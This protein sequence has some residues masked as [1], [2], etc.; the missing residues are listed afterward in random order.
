MASMEEAAGN[1]LFRVLKDHNWPY[2]VTLSRVSKFLSF[3]AH[4]SKT[5]RVLENIGY[6]WA[7]R[8][9]GLLPPSGLDLFLD[10]GR[11]SCQEFM[12][13]SSHPK[14]IHHSMYNT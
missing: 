14:P 11:T 4:P 8:E 2:A 12:S 5:F 6:I 9:C 13:S 1:S 3:P 7:R 10:P